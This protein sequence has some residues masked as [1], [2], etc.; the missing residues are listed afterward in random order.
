MQS[1]RSSARH[2]DSRGATATAS[3]SGPSGWYPVPA[4]ELATW[5]GILL[6]TDASLFQFPYWNEPLRALHFRPQ[7]L[8][9]RQDQVDLAFVCV[10]EL[11]LPGARVALAARGPVPLGSEGVLPDAAVHALAEWSKGRGHLFLRLTHHR[12]DLLRPWADLA[13]RLRPD[14]FPFYSEPQ[15]ELL[16]AQNASDA[17]VA[18]GFQAVARRNL[19]RGQE[20]GYRIESDDTPELL[21]RVWPLFETLSRRKNVRYRRCESFL[22]LLGLARAH[23]GARTFV[24]WLGD[25][26]VQAILVAR[27]RSTAHYIAGALDTEAVGERESPSVLLHWVAM[28]HF[29]AAG[30]RY[31]DLGTRSGQVYQFKR[32]FHPEYHHLPPPVVLVSHP[33]R[34]RCWSMLADSG[35]RRLW[36]RL[37]RL[38]T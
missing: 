8:V 11:G 1:T 30:T 31:Y 27:D 28:R 36:P 3:V 35:V 12:E 15:E 7:Y 33:A 10:L 38:L 21:A 32:K 17:D 18:A 34:F 6:G 22:T 37:K 26:A 14:P 24:A 23:D 9:Y 29:A 13:G 19:R 25:R 20:A 2:S 4:P 16:V 5:N